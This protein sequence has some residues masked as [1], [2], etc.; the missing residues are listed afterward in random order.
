MVDEQKNPVSLAIKRIS[1]MQKVGFNNEQAQTSVEITADAII[2]GVE[3]VLDRLVLLETK[4]ENVETTLRGE[5]KDV[6]AE[7]KEIEAKLSAEIRDVR[8][9][10]QAVETKLSAEIR[11]V[12]AEA[13]EIEAKL[14]AE[15]RDVRAGV[16][17]VET[18]LVAQIGNIHAEVRNMARNY[19][20]T[21]IVLSFGFLGVIIA[22]LSS[23]AINA[24]FQ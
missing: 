7:A 3:P 23:P 2:S 15:I 14:S 10:V 5:I 19:H 1:K 4:I 8:A 13:K 24:F 17:A 21:T 12:R 11:D 6:R 20:R 9:G 16:Q 18:R 22:I